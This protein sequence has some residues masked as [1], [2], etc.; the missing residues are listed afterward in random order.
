VDGEEFEVEASLDRA[1]EYHFA[2]L[3]GPNKGYGFGSAS[4]N[5][6]LLSESQMEAS[7]QNFLVQVDPATGYIE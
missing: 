3:S 7:I 5:G 6:G 2:W 4:S 1:G